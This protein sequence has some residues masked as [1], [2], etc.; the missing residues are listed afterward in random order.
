MKQTFLRYLPN[1]I[2]S[3]RVIAV[4]PI[5]YFLWIDEFKLA[6]ILF[7]FAGVSDGVDGYLARRYNWKSHWGAVMDPLADKLLMV[8]TASVLMFKSLLP[9]WLFVLIMLRDL[10]IVLGAAYYRYRFGP[11]QVA[12]TKLG[13]ASTFIQILMVL[14][15]LLH[16]ATGLM[17]EQQIIFI[18]YLCAFVTIISG[19]Q[20][21]CIWVRRASHE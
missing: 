3:I 1:L 7:A 4:L 20:Y 14:S 15:L 9:I 13:K 17:S 21:V 19:A 11:F 6:L 2:T 18:I 12:P 5:A 16:K 8:V 10:M